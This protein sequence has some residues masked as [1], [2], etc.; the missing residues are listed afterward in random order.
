MPSVS[1]LLSAKDR[2]EGGGVFSYAAFPLLLCRSANETTFAEDIDRGL[3]GDMG[4]GSF[5]V[6]DCF[7]FFVGGCCGGDSLTGEALGIEGR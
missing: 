2:G 1:I 7:R 3:D 6:C 4:D 5:E